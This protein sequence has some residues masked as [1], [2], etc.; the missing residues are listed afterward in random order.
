VGV[1]ARIAEGRVIGIKL[2]DQV[3]AAD[4]LDRFLDA[5]E[6][7]VAVA[8]VELVLPI[9]VPALLTAFDMVVSGTELRQNAR[10][11]FVDGIGPVLA[12]DDADGR[13]PDIFD[14][15]V[16]PEAL[17]GPRL[18]L[19][20][21]NVS[22]ARMP[23]P[24][25]QIVP[26]LY[27]DVDGGSAL[28]GNVHPYSRRLVLG[29]AF[30]QNL[31]KTT[32]CVQDELAIAVEERDAGSDLEKRIGRMNESPLYGENLD[33]S[34]NTLAGPFVNDPSCDLWHASFPFFG[35]QRSS[36]L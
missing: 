20:V 32:W 33:P 19:V 16:Q 3:A 18:V 24:F 12:F 11:V 23:V 10:R 30:Y 25:R 7:D 8:L 31:I 36:P 15:G 6:H 5:Q 26:A 22:V 4:G 28:A 21:V 35:Y 2:I 27:F 1:I 17:I 34:G 13:D 14:P 29:P 9:V